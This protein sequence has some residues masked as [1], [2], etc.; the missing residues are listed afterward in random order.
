MK[1][2]SRAKLDQLLKNLQVL[3]ADLRECNPARRPTQPK[4]WLRWVTT[5]ENLVKDLDGVLQ[6]E[7]GL[8]PEKSKKPEET[9]SK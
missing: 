4:Y 1:Y 3:S 7:P 9:A 5:V 6:N 8:A 2:T